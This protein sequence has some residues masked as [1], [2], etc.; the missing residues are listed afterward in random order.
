MKLNVGS[1]DKSIRIILAIVI[2]ALGVYFKSWW[3]A[4]ALVPLITAFAGIC[5][6]YKILGISTRNVSQE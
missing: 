6:L 5:P 4:V 2:A 3:G 1:A